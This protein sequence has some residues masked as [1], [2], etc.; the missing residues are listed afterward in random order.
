MESQE[1]TTHTHRKDRNPSQIDVPLGY[2]TRSRA[3]PC[4]GRPCERPVPMS[5]L[6]TFRDT[7]PLSFAL[8]AIAS[9]AAL[10]LWL[11]QVR[12]RGIGLGVAGV[13]FSGLLFGHLRLTPESAVLHFVR[14]LGLVLFVFTIGLQVGPTFIASVRAHGRVHNALAASIVGLGSLLAVLLSRVLRIDPAAVLGV[15]S[16]ATTNTPSLGAAQDALRTMGHGA[17]AELPALG[18][19][20]TYPFGIVGIIVAMLALKLVFRID[21]AREAAQTAQADAQEPLARLHVVVEN[22]NLEGAR[23]SMIPGVSELGVIVS[24]HK[25]LQSGRVSVAKPGTTIRRGDTLLAVGPQAKLDQFQMIVGKKSDEDLTRAEGPITSERVVVSRSEVQG[26]TLQELGLREHHGVAVTRVHRGEVQ[27]GAAPGLV[28]HVGDV[29]QV[30]GERE[31]VAKAA[32]ELGNSLS[33]LSQTNYVPVFVGIALGVLVGS[34]PIALPFAPVPLKLG[35]AGGPL[36]VAIALARLGKLGPLLWYMP[37][38]TNIALRELGIV[39]FLACVG[40]KGGEHFMEVLQ[41]G[42][43]LRFMLAGALITLV[44]LLIVAAFGRAVLHLRFAELCGVLSGSMTDPPA[45]AFATAMNGS[46][47]PAVAYAAVYPLTML[48]RIVL[49]QVLALFLC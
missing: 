39:F 25:D 40:M 21:P 5:W 35:L 14:D 4:T 15:L 23:I 34:V 2:A 20:V 30:V 27:M 10:G 13:L 17:Q 11:G 44:P 19:A 12:V 46:D 42:D 36:L 22:Q 48:L 7:Q 33:K 31:A 18:Y 32:Q 24:R 49:A 43:G 38:P 8:L 1:L 47:A 28:L 41:S 16:G 9:V 37:G 26:K 3:E 6:Q 45:L 29:L